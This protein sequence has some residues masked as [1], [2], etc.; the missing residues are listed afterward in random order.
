MKHLAV[1]LLVFMATT[2][3]SAQNDAPVGVGAIDETTALTDSAN[4]VQQ[5]SPLELA[6]E[7]NARYFILKN[8]P[9]SNIEERGTTLLQAVTYYVQSTEQ[10][11]PEQK[12]QVKSRLKQLRPELE[13][14]GVYYSSTGYSNKAYPF[15]EA[16]L[17]IPHLPIFDGEQFGHNTNYNSYSTYVL[18]A[19]NIA[20]NLRN[21]E[22]SVSFY[23][24]YLDLGE[25]QGQETCYR[26]LTQ[27]LYR[28]KKNEEAA[29]YLEEG[30][31]NFPNSIGMLKLSIQLNIDQNNLEKARQLLNKAITLAPY[32][33]S[34]QITKADLEFANEHYATA[35]PIYKHCYQTDP[36][37]HHLQDKLALCHYNLAAQVNNEM[38]T[39]TDA[40]TYQLLRDSAQH[41]FNAAISL[42]T[43]I[44][45]QRNGKVG[46][47]LLYVLADS[48]QLTGQAEMAAATRQRIDGVQIQLELDEEAKAEEKLPN[49][50]DWYRPQLEQEL[51]KWEQ[52]G[53]F[54]PAEQ[55]AQRVNPEKRQELIATKR[56]QLEERYLKEYSKTYNIDDLTMKGY[57]P[58]HETFCIKTLQGNLYLHVPLKN[59]EPQKFKES[60]NAVRITDPVFKVD[61]QGKIQLAKATFT[62]PHGIN[63]AYDASLPLVYQKIKV[64]K[65]EWNDDDLMVAQ[66]N[67]PETNK[68]ASNVPEEMEELNVGESIVDVDVPKTKDV[69]SNTFALIIANENYDNVEKVPYALNDGNSFHRYCTDLLGIPQENIFHK[70]DATGNQMIAA[71]DEIK[72]Y[73]KAYTGMKL[74]VYY[75]GHGLPDPSSNEAYLLP[76]DASPHNINTGYKL[77]RFYKELAAGNPS[78]ITVF[79]DA[80]FSGAKKDGTVMDASAKGVVIAPREET[81]VSNMVVFSACTGSETAYPYKN[82][83][84]GLFTFFLLKKLKEDNGRT[85]YQKLATYISTEVKKN[86]LRLNKKIQ[87]PQVQ[88]ALPSSEWGKWRLDKEK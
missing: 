37:N 64:A 11:S 54:E 8:G 6:N 5:A 51:K 72:N 88:S 33:Q 3:T 16:F 78:S 35:L 48:Y 47:N 31:I 44:E 40:A 18:F 56:K 75:S 4:L 73:A 67:T 2:P 39:V 42:I 70:K 65:P 26:V 69:N 86:S 76:T 13:D 14:V 82:Q 43:S 19:A 7:A 52:R 49:F 9:I 61:K 55:Y 15:I 30:L 79:I 41:N 85:P 71:I 66:N 10:L 59:E 74:L 27:D 28:L 58:D 1:L 20:H 63:Y 53:E 21:W 62:T 17:N 87:S 36:G 32:E 80:C 50:N 57:D 24:E 34:L 83:R 46:R 77:S 38:N 60:W 29:H 81:P 45:Q 23:K 68:P 12:E 22:S 25:K 84:H